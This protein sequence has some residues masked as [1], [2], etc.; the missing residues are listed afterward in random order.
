LTNEYICPII[1]C[2]GKGPLSLWD[3]NGGSVPAKQEI[4]EPSSSTLPCF[5][6]QVRPRHEKAAA[7]ALHN[8]GFDEFLPLYRSRR[9][10]SDRV[11]EL[12]MPLFPGYVFCRFDP[13]DRLPILTTPGVISLVGIGKTPT[14]VE[15]AELAALRMVVQSGLNAEPWPFL[16]VGQ[17]VRIDLGPLAG[18]EGILTELKNRQRLIVSVGLLQRSV[19]VEIDGAWVSPICLGRRSA[20]SSSSSPYLVRTQYA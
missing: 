8:K 10:W 3:L 9:R 15:E 5:A 14:P 1:E 11:K 18:L 7:W 16:K 13:E 19:A 6:L 4:M 2:C 17:P 20:A 12:D